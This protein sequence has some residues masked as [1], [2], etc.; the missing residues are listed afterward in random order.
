[1]LKLRH[2]AAIGTITFAGIRITW[3]PFP[4]TLFPYTISQPSSYRHAVIT[5]AL[6]HKADFFF[7]DLGSYT[8]NVNVYAQPSHL[9][10]DQISLRSLG[11]RHV[12]RSGWVRIQGKHLQLERGEFHGIAG[13][14][15]M[16]QVTFSSHGWLWH[17]T[18]SY[19]YRYRSMRSMMLRMIQSFKAR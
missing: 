5:D 7:P 18:A 11:A 14:W 9:V 17:L 6:G 15:I 8:T 16:E 2:L 10:R 19:D 1:M 12:S 13:H 3:H 4:S